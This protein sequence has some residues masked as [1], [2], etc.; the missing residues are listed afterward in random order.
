MAKNKEGITLITL[1]VIIIV[2]IILTSIFIATS[3]KALDETRDTELQNEINVLEQAISSRYASYVNSNGQDILIGQNPIWDT[4]S[5]CVDV[6]YE[7]LDFSDMEPNDVL[8][9]KN[10]ISKEIQRDYDTYVRLVSSGDAALLG[11]EQFSKDDTFI[12][13]YVTYRGFGPIK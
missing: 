11:I 9:K 4:Y 12:V 13:D 10:R 3:L 1:I 5:E 7:T 2:L 6:I 8:A